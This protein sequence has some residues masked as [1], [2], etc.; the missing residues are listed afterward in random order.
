MESVLSII[1]TMTAL[2]SATIALTAFT[3]ESRLH[4]RIEKLASVAKLMERSPSPVI[5]R[6]LRFDLAELQSREAL[7]EQQR[8]QRV[9]TLAFSSAVIFFAALLSASLLATVLATSYAPDT[10]S[11]LTSALL[12]ASTS[13]LSVCLLAQG[14]LL[15]FKRRDF[16]NAFFLGEEL[17]DEEITLRRLHQIR[18]PDVRRSILTSVLLTAACQFVGW[19]LALFATAALAPM[20]S[21]LLFAAG[22]LA[23]AAAAAFYV[24]AYTPRVRTQDSEA[25]PW[26]SPSDFRARA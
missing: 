14:C 4:R 12:W 10:P 20:Y 19:A 11:F 6:A 23:G 15:E 26:P 3:A 9:F 8:A 5:H 7:R 24:F 25:W 21:E 16:R 13:G 1:G 18:H 2:I 22:A 17:S